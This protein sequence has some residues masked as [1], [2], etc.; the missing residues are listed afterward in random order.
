MKKSP[1]IQ[2][3]NTANTVSLCEMEFRPKYVQLKKNVSLYSSPYL[4]TQAVWLIVS[5][6]TNACLTEETEAEDKYMCAC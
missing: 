5:L 2:D 4:M 3:Q 1:D 6:M